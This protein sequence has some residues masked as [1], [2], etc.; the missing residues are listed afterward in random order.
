MTLATAQIYLLRACD[1]GYPVFIWSTVTDAK[2]AVFITIYLWAFNAGSC[3]CCV[4]TYI[5]MKN[6]CRFIYDQKPNLEYK[7]K[8]KV[9]SSAFY[10]KKSEALTDSL[11]CKIS[12]NKLEKKE[13]VL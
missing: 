3:L 1:K 2:T 5:N 4:I 9:Q 7:C 12:K 8:N 10:F 13:K 6:I 11:K